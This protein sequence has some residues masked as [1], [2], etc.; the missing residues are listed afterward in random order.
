MV[1]LHKSP[2]ERTTLSSTSAC[3]A[4]VLIVEAVND[5][6]FHAERSETAQTLLPST[7]PS[8]TLR[9]Q[10]EHSLQYITLHSRIGWCPA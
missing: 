10:K 3:S 2:S 7:M 5:A 9:A 4:S 8:S 6:L 1:R